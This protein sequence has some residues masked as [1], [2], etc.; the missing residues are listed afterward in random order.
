MK[1]NKDDAAYQ[2]ARENESKDERRW[3][4]VEV[5]NAVIIR[6]QGE[7]ALTVYETSW[8]ESVKSQWNRK[9]SSKLTSNWIR[10]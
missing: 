4:K 1:R 8:V 10:F 7:R 3:I 5:K 9:G 2:H 6:R